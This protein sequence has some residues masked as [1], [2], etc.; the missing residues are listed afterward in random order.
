MTK[1][2]QR[3]GGMDKQ[4]RSLVAGYEFAEKQGN[5]ELTYDEIAARFPEFDAQCFRSGMLDCLAGDPWRCEIA[6]SHA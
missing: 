6:R 5:E 4:E 1:Q 3:E 2:T